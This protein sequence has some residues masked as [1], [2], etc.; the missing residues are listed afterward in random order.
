[1]A[2]QNNPQE[3][4]GWDKVV[5]W[6]ARHAYAVNMVYSLGASV[7]IVGALFKILHWPGAS[8]VLMVGMFTESF[9]FMLGIFEKPH[10]VYNWE[11][12]FPQLIGHEEKE[13]LGG[14]GIPG[15]VTDTPERK[16]VDTALPEAELKALQ[17]GIQ[18]LSKTAQQLASIGEVADA[19][20]QLKKTITAA[21]QGLETAS[22]GL[23]DNMAKAGKGIEDATVALAGSLGK[24]G[25]GVDVAVAAAA[26]NIAKAGEAV[27]ESQQTLAKN[28]QSLGENYDALAKKYQAVIADMDAVIAQTKANGKGLE[29]VNAQ[30]ASLNSVYEL[31]LKEINAQAAA[32]RAQTE[33]VNGVS[34]TVD[35]LAQD[36]KQIQAAAAQALEAG[37]QYQTA[38]QKLAQQIADLNKV[39]GNMLNALA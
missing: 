21:G 36:T 28:T 2:N 5:A 10:A 27:A 33:K 22:A 23:T 34:A 24:A 18:N 12:V 7:V 16:T 20:A 30:I 13:L 19:T 14:N 38:Q 6:Y 39:Y 26:G 31:Q 15:N 35:Q 3:L 8:Y 17:E 11:N 1:M 37:K 25:Q 4:K 29:S 32:F 9:L